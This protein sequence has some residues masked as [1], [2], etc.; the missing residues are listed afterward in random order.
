MV[1]VHPGVILGVCMLAAGAAG[2]L[3]TYAVMARQHRARERENV[4]EMGKFIQAALNYD[5]G[6]RMCADL[7]KSIG[8]ST[9]SARAPAASARPQTSS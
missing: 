7:E 8:K 9:Q 2:A 6:K 3:A 1:A 5:T 4:L